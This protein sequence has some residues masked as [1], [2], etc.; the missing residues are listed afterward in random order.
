ML[1]GPLGEWATEQY[2]GG[3][4]VRKFDTGATRDVDTDKLDPEGFIH[5]LVTL[6]YSRYMHA[7]RKQKDGSLR[8]SDNWQQG[9]P[10]EAYVKS[11]DRHW[12]DVKLH[13]R[14]CGEEAREDLETAL[15]A[16]LFNVQG[17]LYEVLKG[18]D[19]R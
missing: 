5:P 2:D 17:L 9:I 14:G 1:E 19:V 7:N 10:R 11:G 6:R 4:T 3:G 12:L 13:Q 16:M 18:R 15:C 8:A